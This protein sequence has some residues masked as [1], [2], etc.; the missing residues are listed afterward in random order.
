[1]SAYLAYVELG[2]PVFR[3]TKAKLMNEA[4]ECSLGIMHT[5]GVKLLRN[6]KN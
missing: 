2:G 3:A 5:C 4:R 6:P 1:M